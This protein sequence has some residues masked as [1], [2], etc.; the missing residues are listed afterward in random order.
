MVHLST[1]SPVGLS[2]R[3]DTFPAFQV[4]AFEL[5]RPHHNSHHQHFIAAMLTAGHRELAS[6]SLGARVVSDTEVLE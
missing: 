6:W 4:R 2:A 5:R 3:A 1:N